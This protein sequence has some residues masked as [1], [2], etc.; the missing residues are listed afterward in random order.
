MRGKADATRLIIRDGQRTSV[1]LRVDG[2]TPLYESERDIGL[3]PDATGPDPRDFR[4]LVGAQQSARLTGTLNRTILDDV[5]ATVTAEVGRSRSRSRFGVDPFEANDPL[6]RN[7]TTDSGGLGLALNKQIGKWRLSSI[8]NAQLDRTE[9]D[10]ERILATALD[11]DRNRSTRRAFSLD[12]TA[13][14]PVARASRGRRQR[15]L[16]G[17]ARPHRPRQPARA[18]PASSPAPTSAA[19]RAKPRPASTCRSPGAPRRSAG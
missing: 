14:G 13:T 4:T 18:A 16:Q 3:N 7:S 19:P 8:A 6:T 11:D 2:N 10:S 15:D 9:G 5:G 17:R 12:G 1:N